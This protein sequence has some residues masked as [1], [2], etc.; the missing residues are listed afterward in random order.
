MSQAEN[1]LSKLE[2]LPVLI[3]AGTRAIAKELADGHGLEA[4]QWLYVD[5]ASKVNAF[6]AVEIMFGRYAEKLPDIVAIVAASK[7][8]QHEVMF[9][10]YPKL[11]EAPPSD[12]PVPPAPPPAPPAERKDMRRKENKAPR[13]GDEIK[14]ILGEIASIEGKYEALLRKLIIVAERKLAVLGELK[15]AEEE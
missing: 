5:S 3:V 1:A 2:R 6:K 10:D 13:K 9:G 14:E 4:N 8:H 11:A 7:K 15:D 12:P